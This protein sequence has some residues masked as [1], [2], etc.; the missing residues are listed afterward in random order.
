MK[1]KT[2]ENSKMLSPEKEVNETDEAQG[3]IDFVENFLDNHG[4]FPQPQ[5]L[6]K[7][8]NVICYYFGSLE[9]LLRAA[10]LGQSPPPLRRDKKKRYCRHC[11][12][13]LPQFRWFFCNDNCERRFAERDD[14]AL[15]EASEEIK[16][17][18]EKPRRRMWHKCKE[19][20]EK[21]KIFL[22]EPLEEPEAKVIC[23]A[24][25]EYQR[26]SEIYTYPFKEK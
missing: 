3:L 20:G 25:P 15:R 24:S 2:L 11:S 18:V 17:L 22:P 8:N 10:W 1:M 16:R 6:L 14:E 13:L 4:R 26:L 12:E 19:C 21:C 7:E 5:E 23:K 9:N